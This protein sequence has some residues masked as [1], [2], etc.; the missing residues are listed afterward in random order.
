MRKQVRADEM[1]FLKDA[2]KEALQPIKLPSRKARK[3]VPSARANFVLLTDT[4]FGLNIFRHEVLTN[5]YTPAIAASR[6][7]TLSQQISQFKI[8]HRNKCK[9][10]HICLGGDLIHGVLRPL[11]D[12]G[13]LITGQFK[14]AVNLLSTFISEQLS[15]YNTV[16]VHLT[17]GNH[18]RMPWK[19]EDRAINDK[20]DSFESMIG[21]ALQ[22]RFTTSQN[23]IFD[24]PE[25]P[26]TIFTAMGHRY[27]LTHGDTLIKTGNPGSNL[28][29]KALE[30]QILKLNASYGPISTVMLG[31]YHTPTYTIVGTADTNLIIGGCMSGVDPYAQSIGVYRSIP[32]QTIWE[33]T[34]QY[35]VGDLRQIRLT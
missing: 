7:A 25:S 24:M 11:S 35:S 18:G 5:E 4:H 23:V 33:A 20:Y 9:E 3:Y 19:G 15:V 34:P 13:L 21:L 17:T 14:L 1:S 26:I 27:A 32:V 31:H 22:A 30:T 29:I 12:N 16:F 28:N 10:L 2:F 6:M 8:E